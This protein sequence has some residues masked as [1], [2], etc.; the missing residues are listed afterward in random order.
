[1][2]KYGNYLIKQVIYSLILEDIETGKETAIYRYELEKFLDLDQLSK[3]T[4]LPTE[5]F[6]FEIDNYIKSAEIYEWESLRLK[7]LPPSKGGVCPISQEPKVSVLE[8]EADV[9]N[10]IE[11]YKKY[12]SDIRVET[13]YELEDGICAIIDTLNDILVIEAPVESEETETWVPVKLI[14]SEMASGEFKVVLWVKHY[15]IGEIG[16]CRGSAYDYLYA[17]GDVEILPTAK[18]ATT[19]LMELLELVKQ[20][21]IKIRVKEE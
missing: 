19:I 17:S 12:F 7:L 13:G 16:C 8:T 1:M 11:N 10:F 2:I 6:Y 4:Y 15:N 9:R 5:D 3:D 21:I 18:L 20:G 14:V